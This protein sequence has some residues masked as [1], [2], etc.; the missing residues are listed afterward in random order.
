MTEAHDVSF[1]GLVLR[2]GKFSKAAGE[3]LMYCS[4]TQDADLGHVLHDFTKKQRA[5]RLS[6][7]T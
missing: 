3:Y 6:A 7:F 1:I 4:N 2:P 5:I